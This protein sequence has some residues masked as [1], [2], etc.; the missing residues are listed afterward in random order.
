M[1]RWRSPHNVKAL[2]VFN[3]NGGHI[4]DPLL[5]R[6]FRHCFCALQTGPYW[7]LIDALDGVMDIRVAAPATYDLATF[8]RAEGF[9]VIETNQRSKPLRAPL[10]TTNCVGC[11]KCVLGIRS[12]ALTPWG[13]YKALRRQL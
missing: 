6:G 11:V 1:V 13:L 10:V 7:V 5:K 4:L 12:A 9:S 3:N 8:Y 2:A